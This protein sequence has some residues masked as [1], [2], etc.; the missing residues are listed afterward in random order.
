MSKGKRI[1][2]NN[3]KIKKILELEEDWRLFKYRRNLGSFNSGN[4]KDFITVVQ[5]E[6]ILESLFDLILHS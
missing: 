2:L 3:T 4:N 5:R 6:K 1:V